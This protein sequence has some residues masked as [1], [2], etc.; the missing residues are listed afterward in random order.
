MSAANGLAAS[1]KIATNLSLAVQ[2][3]AFSEGVLLAE[4]S[5]IAR[6]TAVEVMLNSVMASPMVKYR[7]PFVL[8]MPDEAWFDVNMM[9]KDLLLALE[10]G[11]QLDVPLPTTSITN[12]F[13]T[14]ARGMGL[15]EKDFAIIF[16]VLA[17][18]AGVKDVGVMEY[19]SGGVMGSGKP[20]TPLLQH[21]STPII[22]GD[23]QWLNPRNHKRKRQTRAS[24]S[25]RALAP[26]LPPDAQ[27]PAVR[28]RGQSTLSRRQ[29]AGAGASLHRRRSGGRRRLRSVAA[30]RLHHQH[31]PRP[32]PLHRQR[33]SAGQNVR[34]AA[35]QR[36][37]LLPRQRRL[38]AYRRPG[39]R[40]PGRQRHRRRQRGHRHRRG[41]VDQDAQAAIKWQSVSSATARSGKGCSTKP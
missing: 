31:P 33:R 23:A 29:D 14:A 25:G 37:R 38:D 4:K 1:M 16:E 8:N 15:A 39:H 18:M 19:W 40:Q 9:Q 30:R 5:G 2:M 24:R 34:R 13:L 10:M 17:R 36:S 32:W 6:E 28:R 3:L 7:G 41:D 27:D 21:S 11:R 26:L 35:R 22:R 12:Q 20:N